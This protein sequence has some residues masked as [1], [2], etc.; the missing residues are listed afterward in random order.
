MARKTRGSKR[1][2][3]QQKI[4]GGCGCSSSSNAPGLMTGGSDFG[5]PSININNVGLHNVIP[6][7]SINTHNHDPLYT[8]VD[9]RQ[10]PNNFLSG[11][12]KRKTK[13]NKSKRR[14]KNKSRKNKKRG[15]NSLLSTFIPIPTS[16]LFGPNQVNSAPNDQPLT[17]INDSNPALI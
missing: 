12:K 5:E 11:G 14:Y 17:R 1:S 15:G 7:Y 6:N 4:R 3:R 16:G 10:L 9:T 2:R 13:Y 8:S